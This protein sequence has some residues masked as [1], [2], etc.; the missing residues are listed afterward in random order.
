MEIIY[1]REKDYIES[2]IN[3]T[4]LV[5]FSGFLYSQINGTGSAW[6]KRGNQLKLNVEG[7]LM[8]DVVYANL[9]ETFNQKSCQGN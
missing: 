8:F 1:T 4:S 7:N 6:C 2:C 3:I 9:G 5:S